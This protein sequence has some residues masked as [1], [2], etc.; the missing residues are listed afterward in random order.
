MA[1]KGSDDKEHVVEYASKSVPQSKRNYAAPQGECFAALWGISHFR[2]YLYGRKFTLVTD[3]EPLKALKT[4]KDYTGMIGRWATILQDLDFDIRHRK[5]EQHG[6]ADGLTRLH[7]P[8]KVPKTEE[9]TPWNETPV[10][11]GKEYGKIQ[12]LERTQKLG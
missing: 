12:I 9:V 8:G 7:R 1:Q 5:H 6:N 10:D 2:A 11:P 4:S 3:H